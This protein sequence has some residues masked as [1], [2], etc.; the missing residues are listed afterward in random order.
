MKKYFEYFKIPFIVTFVIIIIC[1]FVKASHNSQESFE[2]GNEDAEK[3][4]N[5]W[6]VANALTDSQREELDGIITDVEDRIGCDVAV[7]IIDES[8]EGLYSTSDASRWVMNFADDFADVHEMG[9][10]APHGDSIVFLDNQYRE[11]DGHVY[12][13]ISTSGR[14]MDEL[15]VSDCESIM[16]DALYDLDDYSTSDDYFR[17]Y[18]RVVELLPVYMGSAPAAIQIFKP[19]YI[20]FAALFIAALYIMINWNSKAGV[21]T[22]SSTT[23]VESGRPMIKRKQDT[24]IRK[25]V[26]KVKIESSS[27]GGGSGGHTSS[28]GFSH[29]GGG[30]SR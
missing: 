8:L 30:H 5:V 21:R 17:A 20:I 7:V 25:S 18:S 13:W 23:Y 19:S 26:T 29:G 16:D 11:S 9:Y 4:E 3:Q 28:G 2:W 27:G 14:G 22:T 24:F 15:T 6:D 12:S 10:D 1:V